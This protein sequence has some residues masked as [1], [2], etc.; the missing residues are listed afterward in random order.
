MGRMA[1]K[2]NIFRGFLLLAVLS[3]LLVGFLPELNHSILLL[4]LL[5]QYRFH[6]VVLWVFLFFILAFGR[7]YWLMIVQL[8]IIIFHGV[9]FFNSYSF[10]EEERSCKVV[11]EVSVLSFNVY[12][13]NERYEQML[14]GIL[15]VDADIVLLL[16]H[17]SGFYHQNHARL[18]VKYPFSHVELEGGFAQ[19]KAIY[20]KYPMTPVPRE[21]MTGASHIAL[22]VEINKKGQ[23]I[24]F[25]GIH[26]AS[27]QSAARIADRNSQLLSLEHYMR[28]ISLLER[29]V[30]VAGDFNS[31]PWHPQMRRFKQRLGLKNNTKLTD[32]FGTWPSW[33]PFFA[34]LPID[35]IYHSA[36]LVNIEYNQGMAAGSDHY[37]IHSNMKI[38]E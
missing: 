27:P 18:S 3:S 15:R 28:G 6:L 7:H 5:S 23:L 35:H 34:R 36:K 38:C 10:L 32:I 20:S 31:T 25:I 4:E 12:H 8:I 21:D 19:G 11:D 30:I 2:N 16:E 37:S 26:T 24:D 1:Y 29:P 13:L 14:R 9:T 22:R 17:K 33:L